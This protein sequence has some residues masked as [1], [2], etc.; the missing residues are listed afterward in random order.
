M[1]NELRI[2]ISTKVIPGNGRAKKVVLPENSRASVW[3][4]RRCC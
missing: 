3:S 1:V 4:S 2:F